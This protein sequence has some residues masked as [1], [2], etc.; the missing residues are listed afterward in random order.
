MRVFLRMQPLDA[1]N[2][3]R[4]VRDLLVRQE[5]RVPGVAQPD[6]VRDLLQRNP[7]ARRLVEGMGSQMETLLAAATDPV[8]EE[9]RSLQFGLA[10]ARGGPM[11]AEVLGARSLDAVAAISA[12]AAARPV[13]ARQLVAGSG[14]AGPSSPAPVP[15]LRPQ[16]QSA[17]SVMQAALVQALLDSQALCQGQQA[18]LV[19]LQ[20]LTQEQR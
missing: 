9:R 6:P 11:P 4:E 15:A 18:R 7:A 20:H 16:L 14:E 10:L 13:H 5:A 8:L 17:S 2:V 1:T 3:L 12:P 19:T